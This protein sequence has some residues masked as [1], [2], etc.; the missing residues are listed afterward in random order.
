MFFISLCTAKI[1]FFNV[2]SLNDAKE[3]D[4][5]HGN[6]LYL[7]TK[8]NDGGKRCHHITTFKYN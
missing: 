3:N 2:F 1:M 8:K 7:Q 6:P 5:Q 4:N